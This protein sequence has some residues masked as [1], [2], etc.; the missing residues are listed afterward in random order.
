MSLKTHLS[1]LESVVEVMEY[2]LFFDYPPSLEEIFVFLRIKTTRE[3]L[4]KQLKVLLREG[5]VQKIKSRNESFFRYTLGEYSTQDNHLSANLREKINLLEKRKI[6][7]ERKISNW[8]FRFFLKFLSFFPQIKLV[9]LSGSLAMGNGKEED[10]IDLFVITARKR[11]FTGRFIM[12]AFAKLLGIHR[13][14]GLIG[15]AKDKVCLN[16]FFDENYLQI[17]AFKQTIYVGHEVLQMKSLISKN[18]IYER[19]LIENDWLFSLFPNARERLG[20]PTKKNNSASVVKNKN[21][22]VAFFTW[23]GDKIEAGLKKV[24]LFLIN[25][26]KTFEIITEGQLWFYPDDFEKKISFLL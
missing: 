4:T 24:Q 3:V 12:I 1:V 13:S 9:G 8:R 23:L 14:R 18:G 21:L 20:K 11:L 2:F 25:R 15:S 19:F 17:P 10:D 7:S 22:I 5:V 6:I 16:L 26:H